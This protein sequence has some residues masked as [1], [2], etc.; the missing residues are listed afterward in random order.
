MILNAPRPN[1]DPLRPSTEPHVDGVLDFI[2]TQYMTKSTK[3]QNQT[4]SPTSQIVS[5][6]KTSSAPIVSTKVN[7]VQSSES[8]GTN[9]KGRNKFKKLTNQPK[10]NKTQTTDVESRNKGKV[11]FPFLICRGDHFTK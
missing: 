11:K 2:Q 7:V 9:K 10:D 6:P 4:T 8:L 3:K 5:N 1:L